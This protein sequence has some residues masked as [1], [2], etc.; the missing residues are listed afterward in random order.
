MKHRV[1]C[2]RELDLF[3]GLNKPDFR[4]VCQ[5]SAK[6]RIAKGCF[7][8]HQ[9]ERGNT[10][11]LVKT[12]K[13]K[14]VRSRED[15]REVILD[16]VG[17]GEVLGEAALF[18]EEEQFF[19]AMALEET[20]VCCFGRAQF[21]QLVYDNPNFAVDIISHLGRKLYRSIQQAGEANGTSVRGR[22]LLLLHRMADKYGRPTPEGTVIELD[23]T[24]QEMADMI[25]A[26]RVMVA[27]VLRELSEAGLVSRSG[28]HYSLKPDP[29]IERNFSFDKI[30]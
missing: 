17:P 1:A 6:K 16:I 9:G 20:S 13:L 11:Y 26:S 12:G 10:V 28:K 4:H 19:S 7:L 18:Q 21:H 8:F 15:G 30:L 3:Q 27:N 14:L 29:C 2:L 23:I 25:G 24:Q 5:S 22:I